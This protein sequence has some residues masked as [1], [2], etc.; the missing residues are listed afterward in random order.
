MTPSIEDGV[1]RRSHTNV[2][3]DVTTMSSDTACQS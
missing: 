2:G 3:D 1:E